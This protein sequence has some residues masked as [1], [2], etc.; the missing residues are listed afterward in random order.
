RY[1]PGEDFDERIKQEIRFLKQSLVLE[2]AYYEHNNLL[3]MKEVFKNSFQYKII[4]EL[5]K[6]EEDTREL[7]LDVLYDRGLISEKYSPPDGKVW[8]K[9]DRGIFAVVPEKYPTDTPEEGPDGHDVVNRKMFLKHRTVAD[10]FLDR[11]KYENALLNYREALKY[12]NTSYDVYNKIG[13]VYRI[14]DRDDE[15]LEMFRKAVELRF[16]FIPAMNNMATIYNDM[17]DYE[18]AVVILRK[19][20]LIN[21]SDYNVHFNLGV[22]YQNLENWSEALREFRISSLIRGD[23]PAPYIRTSVILKNLDRNEDAVNALK[24]ALPLVENDFETKKKVE[25]LLEGLK[26]D[27]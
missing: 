22:A 26:K 7:D 27:I 1:F 6:Y 17:G 14:L 19:A 10:G 3:N 13:V 23:D 25:L 16:D 18:E 21:G 11:E 9:T 12:D 2:K 24:K 5:N 15:A 8:K 4:P 20:L